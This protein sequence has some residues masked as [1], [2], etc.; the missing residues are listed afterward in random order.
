MRLE[1]DESFMWEQVS[2]HKR[3]VASKIQWS[4][5]LLE[6]RAVAILLD[7]DCRQHW[8]IPEDVVH[9]KNDIEKKGKKYYAQKL[10]CELSNSPD[11]VS[12]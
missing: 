6:Y 10:V 9:E 11:T 8:W 1:V 3:N 7:N 2:I 4:G 12:V 5:S